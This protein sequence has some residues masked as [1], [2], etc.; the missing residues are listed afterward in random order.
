MALQAAASAS[1]TANG[2]EKAETLPLPTL[3]ASMCFSERKKR[4]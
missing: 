3:H 1:A 2:V 4:G